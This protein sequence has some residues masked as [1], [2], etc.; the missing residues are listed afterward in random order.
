MEVY[1]Q[2]GLAKKLWPYG[3]NS[4]YFTL[5]TITI[6]GETVL[7]GVPPSRLMTHCVEDTQFKTEFL[8]KDWW[9]LRQVSILPWGVAIWSRKTLTWTCLTNVFQPSSSEAH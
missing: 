8:E 7:K 5:Y 4:L 9:P 2:P 1:T 3:K 6:N